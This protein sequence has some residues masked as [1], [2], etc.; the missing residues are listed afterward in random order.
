VR[1]IKSLAETRCH[2]Y[3]TCVIHNYVIIVLNSG[4]DSK[5][6]V[7]VIFPIAFLNGYPGRET[8]K[9]IFVRIYIIYIIIL[10]YRGTEQIYRTNV[11][12]DEDCQNVTYLALKTEVRPNLYLKI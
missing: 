8:C 11:L 9:T 3:E 1:S 2:T 4:H 12:Q 10:K 5:P 6:K 7:V